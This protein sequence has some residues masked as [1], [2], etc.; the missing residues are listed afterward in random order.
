MGWRAVVI[1][2]WGPAQEPNQA[3]LRIE[4]Q[5]DHS[6][7]IHGRVVRRGVA[8]WVTRLKVSGALAVGKVDQRRLPL[9]DLFSIIFCLETSLCPIVV[10]DFV[11]KRVVRIKG[12]GRVAQTYGDLT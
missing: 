11:I 8:I 9:S 10:F 7:D 3:A 4:V 1:Q 6:G 5:A 2:L 12:R